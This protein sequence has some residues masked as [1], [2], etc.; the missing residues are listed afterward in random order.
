MIAPFK[1]IVKNLRKIQSGLILVSVHPKPPQR[2]P[3]KE[4]QHQKSL[5]W[6]K[7]KKNSVKVLF[8]DETQFCILVG[9]HVPRVCQKS[10]EEP[11]IQGV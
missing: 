3:G 1:K 7:N 8:S 9:H 11:R 5:N 10:G 4:R 6:A 2:S